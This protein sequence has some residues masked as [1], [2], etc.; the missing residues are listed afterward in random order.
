MINNDFP[1]DPSMVLDL[2]EAFRRSKAMFA[3]VSLGVFDAL[4]SG[5]KSLSELAVQIKAN[6]DALGRLLDACVG[7]G[8]LRKEGGKYEITPGV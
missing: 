4:A 1:A 6:A 5:A 8:L 7:L 2:L 3:A